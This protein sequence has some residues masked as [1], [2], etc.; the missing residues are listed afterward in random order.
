M[1]ILDAH[2]VVI[3][4]MLLNI[5]TRNFNN[6]INMFSIEC[7]FMI[8]HVKMYN[9]CILHFQA[10]AKRIKKHYGDVA[11]IRILPKEKSFASS[12]GSYEIVRSLMEVCT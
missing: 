12:W 10:L 9:V 8:I 7:F 4:K 1:Y 2:I 11:N 6:N 3:C 5:L